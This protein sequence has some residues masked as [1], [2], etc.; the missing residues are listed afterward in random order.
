MSNVYFGVLLI[1]A[2]IVL[3]THTTHTHKYPKL[4]SAGEGYYNLQPQSGGGSGCG[5]GN[6]VVNSEGYSYVDEVPSLQSTHR[7]SS[8][9]QQHQKSTSASHR[10]YQ[11]QNR[12]KRT[13]RRVTH[14]EKRYHSGINI[15]ECFLFSSKQL[16][17]VVIFFV[18]F[19]YTRKRFGF[20]SGMHLRD[21][22]FHF[23]IY[24]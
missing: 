17:L 23:K 13:Q 7:H 1:Y 6:N 11:Q 4:S 20:D 15:V 18:L 22:F 3:Y 9:S 16:C 12:T 24:D 5:A 10:D 8:S 21:F 14:N 2:L 19:V